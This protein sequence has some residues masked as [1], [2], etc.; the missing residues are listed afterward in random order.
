MGYAVAVGGRPD[1]AVSWEAATID[2]LLEEL[3]RLGPRAS[4]GP[5]SVPK[6]I[7]ALA[8]YARATSGADQDVALQA[9][10]RQLGQRLSTTPSGL[11]K[12]VSE[13]RA[14]LQFG[15]RHDGFVEPV[16]D[17]PTPLLHAIAAALDSVNVREVTKARASVYRGYRGGR[18][19]GGPPF[20]TLRAVQGLVERAQK[21]APEA[22]AEL[23]EIR[24]L[25]LALQDRPPPEPVA[26]G[27][28]SR[29]QPVI[30]RRGVAA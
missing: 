7:A 21:G 3:E 26:C 15:L 10:A 29:S 24:T 5:L 22:E 4:G 6:R 8:L 11:K 13:A 27:G 23:D 16:N 12:A 14:I 1:E 19:H 25:L 18:R 30:V 9:V 20:Q 17:A 28:S 2:M